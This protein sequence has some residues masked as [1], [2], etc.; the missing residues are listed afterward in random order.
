MRR[1]IDLLWAQMPRACDAAPHNGVK[2][3]QR[4]QIHFRKFTTERKTFPRTAAS[5]V[6]TS[7]ILCVDADDSAQTDIATYWRT[8]TQKQSN[9]SR[10]EI[11]GVLHRQLCTS[12]TSTP[13]LSKNQ[14][15]TSQARAEK[16]MVIL[17]R[18]EKTYRNEVYQTLHVKGN[19]STHR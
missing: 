3:S 15:Q 12:A 10:Y 8:D 16:S 5:S 9:C 1:R 19:A 13:S 17:K 18:F 4:S 7:I 14:N 6:N 2:R 11:F